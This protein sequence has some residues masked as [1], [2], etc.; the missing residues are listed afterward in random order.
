MALNTEA[1]VLAKSYT[2]KSLDGQGYIKGDKG[3][4]GR[5]GVDGKDGA[6]VTN[7]EIDD[8]GHLIAYYENG[9]SS[10]CGEIPTTSGDIDTIIEEK[11]QEQF[12][13]QMD[14][15]I[16]EKVEKAV[17]DALAGLGGGGE[18]GD[19]SSEIEDEIDSW[20]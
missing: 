3:D 7:M 2:G 10:D 13:T 18:G 11:V 8:N 20:F 5:D 1:Y 12:E 15:T 9:T 16:Q 6:S 4:P 14:D 17:E 19:S